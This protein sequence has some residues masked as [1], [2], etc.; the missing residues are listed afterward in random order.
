[1]SPLHSLH[2]PPR[3]FERNPL[4][5]EEDGGGSPWLIWEMGENILVSL[6]LDTAKR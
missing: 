1:M 6:D 2:N 5:D 3:L 4:S